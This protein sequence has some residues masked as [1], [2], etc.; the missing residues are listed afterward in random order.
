MARAVSRC[1]RFS[2]QNV[3][4]LLS[5][6]RQR[7]IY[8]SIS[9][10]SSLSLSLSL[11]QGTGTRM[12]THSRHPH[13][14]MNS[15]QMHARTHAHFQVL[16]IHGYHRQTLPAVEYLQECFPLICMY[17]MFRLPSLLTDGGMMSQTEERSTKWGCQ[18]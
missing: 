13:T 11:S 15:Q 2:E 7:C 5:A 6:V 10:H 1:N 9:F 14:N 12:H 3:A 4:Q 8:Q 16:H 17:S 18:L